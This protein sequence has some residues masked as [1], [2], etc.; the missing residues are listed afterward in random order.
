MRHVKINKFNKADL[1]EKAKAVAIEHNL[2]FMEYVA[3]HIPCDKAT[4][5]RHIPINSDEFNALKDILD[6][7]KVKKK[8]QLLSNWEKEGSAPALQMGLFKLLA[9][10]DE[11]KKLSL[12]YNENVNPNAVFEESVK[13]MSNEEL[14]LE[15]KKL[16]PEPVKKETRGR[17]PKG[18]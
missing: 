4:L 11:L 9:N 17:K 12:T 14:E 8:V 16:E 13:R 18:N 6:A 3:A 7:N 10:Q 15:L 5:Y 2:Y 1:F